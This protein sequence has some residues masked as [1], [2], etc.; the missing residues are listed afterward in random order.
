MKLFSD[1]THMPRSVQLALILA[2]TFPAGYGIAWITTRNE[3]DS[4]MFF[5]SVS[6][7]LVA[8]LA[9]FAL[10]PPRVGP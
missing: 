3:F 9:A 10:F 1:R 8:E 6:L 4:F 2:P 7:L 5:I